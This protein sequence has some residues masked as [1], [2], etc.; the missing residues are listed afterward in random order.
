[1]KVALIT[2]ETGFGTLKRWMAAWTSKDGIT[3][4]V[5]TGAVI[6]EEH[7]ARPSLMRLHE[8]TFATALGLAIM[9]DPPKDG[10]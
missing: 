3:R 5:I 4:K 6:S 8:Q 9:Q 7:Q 2:E 10:D 1:M